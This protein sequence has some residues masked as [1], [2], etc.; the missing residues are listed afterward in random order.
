M[1]HRLQAG[2]HFLCLNDNKSRSLTNILQKK[3]GGFLGFRGFFLPQKVKDYD[4]RTAGT[5][6]PTV[7][8]SRDRKLP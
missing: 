3:I 4:L 1:L 6:T 5:F 2:L 8:D 7:N